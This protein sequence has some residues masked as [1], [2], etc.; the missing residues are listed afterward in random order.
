[1][2]ATSTTSSAAS[3]VDGRSVG[4]NGTDFLTL[5]MFA[6]SGAQVT[7]AHSNDLLVGDSG[8]F[9]L[10]GNV[11]TNAFGAESSGG[12]SFDLSDFPSLGGGGGSSTGGVVMANASTGANGLAH[13]LRQQQQQQLLAHQHMMPGAGP[14]NSNLYR[15][16][17]IIGANG[18]FNMASEDFPALS[19]GASSSTANGPTSGSALTG[20]SLLS[21]NVSSISR[22]S[23][24]TS[25]GGL[26]ASEIDSGLQLPVDG[27]TALLGGTTGLGGLGGLRGLSQQPAVSRTGSSAGAIG[28]PSVAAAGGALSGDYGLLGLLGVIRMTDADRNALAVGSDL[29]L[30]GLNL[31]ST[32]Q[33]YSTFSGPFSDT[34]T[35]KEPHFQVRR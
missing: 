5:G 19:T 18:N 8:A 27:A 22:A 33:I 24:A 9:S 15:N 31:G 35:T 23:S 17:S 12:T 20:S 21:G 4:G 25:G 3:S 1:M 14:K 13:V 30:L 34:A 10:G 26:Y 11:N 28:T 7:P 32:E 2:D 16:T 6:T 29:T